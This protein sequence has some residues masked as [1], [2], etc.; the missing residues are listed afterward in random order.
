MH[1]VMKELKDKDIIKS[2]IDY[3]IKFTRLLPVL[4]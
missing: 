3:Q 2:I 1:F 4:V